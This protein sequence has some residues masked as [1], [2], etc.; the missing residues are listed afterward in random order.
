MIVAIDGPA[1]SGKSTIAKELA[2]R[3]GA[4][5]L[6]T[7]AIYRALT[8]KALQEGTDVDDA[9]AL[10]ELAREAN[11]RVTTERVPGGLAQK[12][13][14]GSEDVSEM[15]RLPE[16]DENVS[17][18][19]RFPQVR[20]EMVAIQRRIAGRSR[21]IVI[22]GRD[23]GTSVFPEAEVKVFVTASTAERARR[24]RGDL[25]NQG[26]EA[27]EAEI[28]E[29]LRRRDQLDTKREAGPLRQAVDSHL[30]DTTNLSVE[31]AVVEILHM[32]HILRIENRPPRE[33]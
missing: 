26:V 23:I 10:V 8:W 12:T 25:A 32:C 28:M 9:K 13:F 2:L 21:D 19:S 16:V 5:Y 22:E 31:D 4:D 14:V 30:I 7:G 24:R 17:H 3:L 29:E 15:V 33:P 20:H 18:V 1:A 6:D 27:T 11:I